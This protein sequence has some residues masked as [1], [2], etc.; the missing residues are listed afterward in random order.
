MHNI[1]KKIR[2]GFRL[3]M[4]L[5]LRFFK[6]EGEICWELGWGLFARTIWKE[7]KVVAILAGRTDGST[8]PAPPLGNFLSSELL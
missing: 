2:W 7:A 5:F 3:Y 6:D 8:P 4:P 1:F